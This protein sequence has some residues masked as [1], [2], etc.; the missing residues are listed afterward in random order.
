MLAQTLIVHAETT[1]NAAVRKNTTKNILL[2]STFFS[3]H[4]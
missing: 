4:T 3:N 2:A 1:A